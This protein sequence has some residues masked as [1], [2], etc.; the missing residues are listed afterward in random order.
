MRNLNVKEGYVGIS[1]T[2]VYGF[3]TDEAA[4]FEERSESQDDHLSVN[5]IYD[6][7]KK[8]ME[9]MLVNHSAKAKYNITVARLSNVYGRFRGELSDSTFLKIL[10]RS[11]ATGE[12]LTTTQHPQ[13]AKDYVFIDDVIDGIL[14]V[15]TQGGNGEVY[16][17]AFGAS[18]T[19]N[20]VGKLVGA[21]ITYKKGQNPMYGKISIDKAQKELG[22]SPKVSLKQ[23]IDNNLLITER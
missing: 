9:S 12:T 18:A 10:I 17:I 22:F 21:H 15:L 5:Y 23:C 13:S 16:N 11:G 3:S 20:E 4:V 1:S 8:L 14:R 2:R 7:A 6:G 19:L